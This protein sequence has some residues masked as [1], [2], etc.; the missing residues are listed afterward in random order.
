MNEKQIIER[1]KT[2]IEIK[3]IKELLSDTTDALYR[4]N[5]IETMDKEYFN[6]MCKTKEKINEIL[7]SEFVTDTESQFSMIE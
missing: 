3:K 1:M 6:F 7:N 2:I 4:N 5:D